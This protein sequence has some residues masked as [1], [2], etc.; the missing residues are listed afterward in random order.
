MGYF[1]NFIY[2][3]VLL[4]LASGLGVWQKQKQ[5]PESVEDSL[6]N[7][8]LPWSG[9][10]ERVAWADWETQTLPGMGAPSL[11]EAFFI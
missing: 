5:R 7:D 8:A 6:Q 4:A 1:Q 3:I 10:A 9:G 2:A 11:W